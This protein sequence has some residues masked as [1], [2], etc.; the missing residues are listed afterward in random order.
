MLRQELGAHHGATDPHPFLYRR[1][2][3]LQA[4]LTKIQDHHASG[5]PDGL[6]VETLCMTAAIEVLGA[7]Q[8]VRGGDL[9][10]ALL[11]A[12]LDYAEAGLA[13]ALAIADLAGVAGLSRFHF[14]L[15]TQRN[16]K[17][18]DRRATPGDPFLISISSLRG[19][20]RLRAP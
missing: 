1:D 11:E 16:R 9:S 3:R 4:S 17:Q 8:S 2:G 12:V 5:D 14:A 10:P 13:A 19:S 20:A 18:G 7:S 6:Y 15:A